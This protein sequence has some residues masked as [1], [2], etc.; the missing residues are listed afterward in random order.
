[1]VLSE[2]G[3]HWWVSIVRAGQQAT[4][5]PL[6]VGPGDLK[7]LPWESERKVV[8]GHSSGGNSLWDSRGTCG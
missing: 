3:C 1:M 7:R 8:E 5:V 2:E 6:V 4:C